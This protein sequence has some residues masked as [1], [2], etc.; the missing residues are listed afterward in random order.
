MAAAMDARYVAVLQVGAGS[1]L[2]CTDHH[3]DEWSGS[4][5]YA[6]PFRAL[7]DAIAVANRHGGEAMLWSEAYDLCSTPG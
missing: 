7:H 6:E 2:F 4:F 3:R 1:R 5:R